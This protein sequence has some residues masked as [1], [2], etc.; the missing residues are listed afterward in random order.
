M[1][2]A[3]TVVTSRILL[4][5]GEL[6]GVLRQQNVQQEKLEKFI[7]VKFD[8]ATTAAKKAVVAAESAHV[9]IAGVNDRLDK[10]NSK[11]AKTIERVASIEGKA[12]IEAKIKADAAI[13]EEGRRKG[14]WQVPR[15]FQFWLS[16]FWKYICQ[17]IIG[18]A[19][20]YGGLVAMWH[21]FKP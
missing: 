8:E 9:E 13:F 14:I 11:T 6:K 4:D 2:D 19:A 3:S 15:T 20:S 16:L 21:F 10:L 5:L 17:P 1:V 18:I 7:A 12:E